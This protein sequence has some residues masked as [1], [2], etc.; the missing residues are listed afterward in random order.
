M[1][2]TIVNKKEK[3]EIL[4]LLNQQFGIKDLPFEILKQGKE[5]LFAI[6]GGINQKI[7]NEIDKVSNIEGIGVYFAKHEEKLDLIRLSIEG[8]QLLGNLGLIKKNILELES[9]KEF[10]NWM[11][12]QEIQTEEFQNLKKQV[13]DKEGFVVIRYKQDFLGIGKIS[14]HKDKIG[15]FI[16]KN[17]RLKLKD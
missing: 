12:G 8:S 14:K 7:I 11:A 4:N 17:R 16:P 15:N 9:K 1:I 13:Q 10:E 6:S 3:K 2:P 5:K